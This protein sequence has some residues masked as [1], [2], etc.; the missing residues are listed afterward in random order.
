MHK[1]Y[2]IEG[3][4]HSMHEN[5]KYLTDISYRPNFQEELNEFKNLIID[6]EKKKTRCFLC[7]FW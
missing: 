5:Q 1:I 7:S 4:S 3:A 2:T 6:L